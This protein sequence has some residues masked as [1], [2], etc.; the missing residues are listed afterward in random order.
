[1][2]LRGGGRGGGWGL[3]TT[4]CGSGPQCAQLGLEQA[5][6]DKVTIYLAVVCTPRFTCWKFGSQCGHVGRWWDL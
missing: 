3:H 1:M 4:L 2:G 6:A 5:E